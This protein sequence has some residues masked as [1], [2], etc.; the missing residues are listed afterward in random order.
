M[1]RERR[2]SRVLRA[3][4]I[5]VLGFGVVRGCDCSDFGI[6]FRPTASYPATQ[7]AKSR[8]VKNHC[9]AV[10][11]TKDGAGFTVRPSR[12][13]YGPFRCELI[14]GDLTGK[15]TDWGEGYAAV[16]LLDADILGSN[17]HEV[18]VR[19]TAEGGVRVSATSGP[20]NVVQPDLVLDDARAAQIAVEHTGTEVIFSARRPG[21]AEYT[22]IGRYE[23]TFLGP[24]IPSFDGNDLKK[25]SIVCLDDLIVDHT[26]DP[27]DLSSP[28]RRA[29]NQAER[30]IDDLLR[31]GMALDAGV[32]D[33]ETARAAIESALDRLDAA[34]LELTGVGKA[35]SPTKLLGGARKKLAKALGKLD[36]GKKPSSIYRK[37]KGI[38]SKT[39]A[40][41]EGIGD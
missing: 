17:Y 10:R 5:A 28:G 23:T 1:S 12:E 9:V 39:A 30:A 35:K 41:I 32:D 8:T 40:G 34:D 2:G 7:V 27:P 21:D 26:A 3:A 11:A 37:L 20:G 4:M 24:F 29:R 22:E 31:A 25:N 14:L 18:R 15:D 38:I 19:K 16:A 33:V 13:V 6:A 36:K